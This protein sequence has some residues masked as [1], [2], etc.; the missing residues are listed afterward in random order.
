MAPGWRKPKGLQ[1]KKRL[2]LKNQGINVKPGYRTPNATRDKYKE[3][4]IITITSIESLKTIDKKTQAALIGKTGKRKKLEIIAEAEKLGIT[5]VNL[6]TETYK[7]NAAKFLEERQK[8]AKARDKKQE[9]KKKAEQEEKAKAE[10]A[11]KEKED[12][13]V[14][15]TE[16][17]KAELSPEEKQKKEK[18]EKDKILTKASVG[19]EK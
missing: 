2:Q 13:S 19:K 16:P 12:N 6:N 11:K 17:G 18:E 9:D 3:L 5:I 1:N 8:A 10:K 15:G 7:E 4:E 14:Q